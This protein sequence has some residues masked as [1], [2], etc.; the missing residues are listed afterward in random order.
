M[1]PIIGPN[2]KRTK[3]VI[4]LPF[5]S[6]GEDAFDEDGK[7]IPG[8]DP[9]EFTVPRF[10]FMPRPAFKQM[11]KT[12]DAVTSKTEADDG[13]SDHERGYEVILATLQPWV[14]Q[15]TYDLLA[16]MPMA[17]LEQISNDW[18]EASSV[19]LGQLRGS[20]NSSKPTKGRSTTTA[21]GMD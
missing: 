17:V 7:P 4:T 12:I 15:S 21:S 20:T 16:D 8:V 9:V 11:M 5:S 3:V 13:M 6:D 19:P 2:N 18:N 14:D 10:D 1:T